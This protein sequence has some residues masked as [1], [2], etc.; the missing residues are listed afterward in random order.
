MFEKQKT[1]IGEIGLNMITHSSP[2]VGQDQVS[3]GVGI[4]RAGMPHPLQIFYGNLAQVG[5]KSKLGN[6]VHFSNRDFTS[7]D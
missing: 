2:E 7:E 5:K 6:K 3:E 4:I 1:S